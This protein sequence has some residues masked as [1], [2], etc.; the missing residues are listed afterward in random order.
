MDNCPICEKPLI[1]VP[2]FGPWC[3]TESCPVDD[4]PLCWSKDADGRPVRH[5]A[6]RTIK[7]ANPRDS[8]IAA[9]LDRQAET[10]HP[11]NKTPE[12]SDREDFIA[13]IRA[14]TLRAAATAIRANN[15]RPE[16]E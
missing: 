16:T 10:H 1:D 9:W 4:D 2:G 3:E 15:F 7:S 11:R 13:F 8:I 5:P 14:D 12:E 6:F